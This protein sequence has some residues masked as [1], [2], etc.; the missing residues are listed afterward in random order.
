MNDTYTLDDFKIVKTVEGGNNEFITA[1]IKLN[2]GRIAVCST[3][4]TIKFYDPFNNFSLHF[5]IP[6]EMN[7]K[8]SKIDSM[9][10]LQN[11]HIALSSKGSE[12][13]EIYSVTQTKSKKEFTI[14]DKD[15]FNYLAPLSKNRFGSISKG[16]CKIWK[17]NLPYSETPIIELAHSDLEHKQILQLKDK[18]IMILFVNC[19]IQLWDLDEYKYIKEIKVNS[20][21]SSIVQLDD[22][23]LITGPEIVN[24]KT[25]SITEYNIQSFYVYKNIIKL[26]DNRA[27]VFAKQLNFELVTH[28]REFLLVNPNKEYTYKPIRKTIKH[29]INIDKHTFITT[30]KNYFDV[31]KY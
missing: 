14:I 8:D 5:T 7:N 23:T 16:K 6:V 21:G 9:I 10:Q 18:E 2:D 28:D 3:A 19:N 27:L 30:K 20:I 22:E 25:E 4:Q 15:T 1:I 31:W 17:G 12:K 24:I 11:D 26:R 29:L 13:L